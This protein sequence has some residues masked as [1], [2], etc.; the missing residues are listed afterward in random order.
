MT[1]AACSRARPSRAHLFAA[2]HRAVSPS[3]ICYTT[4]VAHLT[5]YLSDDVETQVRKAAKEAKVSV[6]KWVADRVTKSIERSWPAEFLSLAGAFPDF[7][8][9][10]QLRKGYGVDVPREN[11][12]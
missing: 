4:L 11:L 1:E 12:D 3:S 7:P 5:I 8:E 2:P 10:D 6:S 9:A